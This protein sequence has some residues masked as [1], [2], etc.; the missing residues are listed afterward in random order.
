MAYILLVAVRPRGWG[1]L[2]GSQRLLGATRKE[3]GLC[4]GWRLQGDLGLPQNGDTA[5]EMNWDR[6]Q[7]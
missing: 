4:H 6:Q 1:C 7:G 3:L 2:W 5:G